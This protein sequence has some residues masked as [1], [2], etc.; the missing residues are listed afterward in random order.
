[1]LTTSAFT[2]SF[3]FYIPWF[4]WLCEGDVCLL[5][6]YLGKHEMRVKVSNMCMFVFVS[7]LFAD[8]VDT[9]LN[10]CKKDDDEQF[11]IMSSERQ[12][13]FD[14]FWLIKDCV[15]D[16][17]CC[18]G[19]WRNTRRKI[20]F[21]S[22]CSG[23]I[24]LV[25]SQWSHVRLCMLFRENNCIH[26]HSQVSF[27]KRETEHK[28]VT[29]ISITDMK[30][31]TLWALNFI[32]SRTEYIS[33]AKNGCIVTFLFEIDSQSQLVV[34]VE[35]VEMGMKDKAKAACNSLSFLEW[36]YKTRTSKSWSWFSFP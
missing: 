27:S 35:N 36:K 28:A 18:E 15:F 16:S 1:M 31:I 24:L 17:W 25:L 6:V 10:S 33:S 13:R 30:E 20:H 4:E 11:F 8:Q 7:L 3:V 14:V 12:M 5:C 29:S 32:L 22:W 19:V 2:F 23:N 21:A 34:V 9:D 26:T